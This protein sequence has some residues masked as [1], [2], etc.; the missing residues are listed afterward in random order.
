MRFV[1]PAESFA[2]SAT[3]GHAILRELRQLD[4]DLVERQADFLREDDEGNPPQHGPRVAAVAGTGPFR[5][6]QS[7]RLVEPK[8][9]GG[10]AAA[11]RH[12]AD[13]QQVEHRKSV[14]IF[15]LDLK[16]TLTC[17]LSS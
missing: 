9:G 1:Q 11:S 13:G 5:P 14:A 2:Q 4:A 6:D 8:R 3:L 16:L 10:D 15:R 17:S 12:L 7:S